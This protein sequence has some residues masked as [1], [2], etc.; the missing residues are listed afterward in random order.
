L[1]TRRN[2]AETPGGGKPKRAKNPKPQSDGVAK[3]RSANP[4]PVEGD[5]WYKDANGAWCLGAACFNVKIPT[6]GKPV[7][8]SFEQ[9]CP[10][11]PMKSSM[12]L[13]RAPGGVLNITSSPG[14]VRIGSDSEIHSE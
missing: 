2:P 4:E 11:A 7:E 3:R 14:M 12:P 10:T 1:V 13:P 6:D 9:D 8:L 5:G